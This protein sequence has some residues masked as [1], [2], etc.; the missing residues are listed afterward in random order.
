MTDLLLS[1]NFAKF[2][3]K[4]VL[5]SNE[6]LFRGLLKKFLTKLISKYG[7]EF[8]ALFQFEVLQPFIEIGFDDVKFN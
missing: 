1:Q 4:N 6:E 3:Q 8:I 2:V 5:D 7:E